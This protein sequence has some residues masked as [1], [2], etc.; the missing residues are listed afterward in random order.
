MGSRLKGPGSRVALTNIS[1]LKIW[2]ELVSALFLDASKSS[3]RSYEARE[4]HRVRIKKNM[5]FLR[6]LRGFRPF[7]V[8]RIVVSSKADALAKSP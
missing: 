3:P 8:N 6:A 4:D 7:A 1:G 5:N 2:A